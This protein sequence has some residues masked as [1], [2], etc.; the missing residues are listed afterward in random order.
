[1]GTHFKTAF[2]FIRKHKLIT[3]INVLSL[4]IGICATLVIFLMIRFDYSFD[5]HLPHGDRV[6]RIVT[7]GEYKNAGVVVPLIR[8]V[9]EEISGLE[10]V[11]PIFDIYQ[12]KIKVQKGGDELSVF[13]TEKNLAF[14]NDKYFDIYP[15]QWLAG[16]AEQLMQPYQIVLSEAYVN[17]YFPQT[18]VADAIGKTILYADTIPLQVAGVVT[19]MPE[20]SDFKFSG[21]ISTATIAGNEGLKQ[22]YNWDSWSNYNGS[23][24]GLVLLT[25]GTDPASVDRS[26]AQL[27]TKH[28][29]VENEEWDQ[30]RLQPLHDVHF[31][32]TFNYEAVKPATLRNLILLAVFLLALGAINFINLSSAQSIE[33]AKEIGI[34]KTLGSRKSGLVKQFLLE[35]LVI[36]GFATLLSL[37]MLPL[38]VHAFQGFLPVGFTINH[39]PLGPTATFLV[40]QLLVVTLLAGFYP[41]WVMTGYAPALALKNQLSKNSNLSRSTWVRKGLTVFQFVLAQVFLI[42]VLVV[43]KQTRFAVNMDMGFEKEAIINFYVPDV[44]RANKGDVLKTKLLEIPEIQAVSFGN[45]S[46]AFSG[47]MV[48]TMDYDQAPEDDKRRSFDARNGDENFID[49]YHIPLVAGRNVRVL[50]SNYEALVNEKMLP[51]LNVETPEEAIGKTFNEGKYTVVGVMKDFHVA[52]AHSDIRPTMYW[53]QDEMRYVMHVALDKAHPESWRSAIDKMKTAFTDVY[54]E[55]PFEYKFLDEAIAGFYQTEQR[56]SQLLSWAVGL[57]IAIAALGLFGLAIFTANQRTKEIGIRKVLG[58]SVAQIILLLAKNLVSLVVVACLIAIPIAWY[59]MHSWLNDFA[60][61]TSLSWWI[62]LMA[63]LGLLVVAVGVLTAKTYY[64]ARANPVDSLR[65]E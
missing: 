8:T 31:N 23:Y 20:N 57:S 24:Q 55:D 61:R 2:R 59:F 13:P 33:R 65:D 16:N 1:M 29:E 42:A 9:E 6:Y 63:A 25:P 45:Q 51:M 10:A 28:K 54:P 11:A 26:M 50:D 18:S 49:V 39:I 53:S 40:A 41:A 17:R 64:A 14:T 56:L 60:Y 35:T 15:H 47:T 5:K 34:R 27:L 44:N 46:P 30:F 22:Q 32:P 43:S 36:A 3:A 7:D 12:A 58:A 62:F 21:F 48:S 38:L 19:E 37:L 52:S 4:S